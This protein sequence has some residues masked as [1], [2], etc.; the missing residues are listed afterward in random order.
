MKI[1]NSSAAASWPDLAWADNEW[2]TVWHDTRH[3]DDEIY[4]ARFDT[5]GNGLGGEVRVTTASG[6]SSYPSVDWNGAQ[7]GISWQDSRSGPPS[8]Y[9]T[10]LNAAGVKTGGDQKISNGAGSSQFTTGVWNGSAY[11]FCF[12]DNRDGP[13]GNSEI[14]VAGMGCL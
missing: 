2:A 10:L 14:Y 4:F 7:F 11:T 6:D 5:G 1:S 8:I 12:R 9:F 13:S 3:G